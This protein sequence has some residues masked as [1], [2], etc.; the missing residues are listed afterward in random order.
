M[1]GYENNSQMKSSDVFIFE[2]REIK[3]KNKNLNS[4]F[5]FLLLHKIYEIE[6]KIPFYKLISFF[7]YRTRF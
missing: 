6:I 7:E 4:C 1:V 5:I 2:K 3:N